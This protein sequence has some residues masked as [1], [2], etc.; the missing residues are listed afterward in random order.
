MP[1][2]LR[3]AVITSRPYHSVLNSTFAANLVGTYTTQH[4]LST[5]TPPLQEL[6]HAHLAVVEIPMLEL[7]KSSNRAALQR[8]IAK[9]K[10]LGVDVAVFV[11]SRRIQRPGLKVNEAVP[12]QYRT[13]MERPVRM[14]NSEGAMPVHL[15]PVCSCTFGAELSALHTRW[16]I[17]TT[18]E[19]VA[20]PVGLG[21]SRYSDDYSDCQSA[22]GNPALDATAHRQPCLCGFVAHV[23]HVLAHRHCGQVPVRQLVDAGAGMLPTVLANACRRSFSETGTYPQSVGASAD[24]RLAVNTLTESGVSAGPKSAEAA[25]PAKALAYPTDSKERE[26]QKKG[27]AQS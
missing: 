6:A 26:K 24:T 5:V 4:I 15:K 21:D 12:K 1:G 10:A 23:S 8:L 25:A 9:L 7:G 13:A 19:G 2:D 22:W 27:E 11:T 18:M 17:G 14:W 3:L 20:A 16:F